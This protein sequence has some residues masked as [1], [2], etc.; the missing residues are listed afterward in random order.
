MVPVEEWEEDNQKRDE[1][2]LLELFYTLWDN[3]ITITKITGSFVI[4]GLFL[5][6]ISPRE[7]EASATLMSETESSQSMSGQ[8]IQQYGGLL[9]LSGGDFGQQ[10]TIS[11]KIYPEIITSIPYQVELMNVPLRFDRYDTT[12]TAYEFFSDI[13]PPSFFDYLKKYTIGLP[14]QVVSLF[15]T[16]EDK[17]ELLLITE[18]DRDSVLSMTKAQMRIVNKLRERITI[19]LS[20][21]V[22][23][24]TLIVE[25]PDSQAAAE[26]GQ[27]GINLLKEYIREYRTQKAI[28]DLRFVEK[29]TEQARKRFEEAQNRLAEFRDNNLNLVTA[30]A[31]VREQQLQSQYDLAFNLY[32]SLSQQLEEDKIRVQKDTPV[33]SVLQPISVP[34]AKSKPNSFLILIIT[35]FLGLVVGLVFVTMRHW[36]VKNRSSFKRDYI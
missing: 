26:M 7:Y 21:S 4:F 30:K 10:G 24:I 25:M 16:K 28:E 31:Q 15:T 27:L 29:Q 6:L 20:N 1:I 13:Y 19:D 12:V 23:L 18:V 17:D 14:R 8:L 11:P 32:N 33:F 34:L 2:D 35:G 9:G 3:R 22:G 5:I 36:W